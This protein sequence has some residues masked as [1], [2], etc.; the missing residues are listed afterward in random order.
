MS[1]ETIIGKGE[2]LKHREFGQK[3]GYV[4]RSHLSSRRD[5]LLNNSLPSDISKESRGLFYS[6]A[7]RKEKVV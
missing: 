3:I 1:L 5:I 7:R 2:R 6:T 4:T